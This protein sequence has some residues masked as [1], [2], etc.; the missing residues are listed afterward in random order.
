M[1]GASQ[2]YI[3]LA[4]DGLVSRSLSAGTNVITMHGMSRSPGSGYT[5]DTADFSAFD[6]I[7]LPVDGF[8]RVAFNV[9]W[10]AA[11]PFSSGVPGIQ[12]VCIVGGTPDIL[13]NTV[14]WQEWDDT[15]FVIYGEQKVSS[16]YD[17]SQLVS[18]FWFNYSG[19][20]IDPS[21]G[22]GLGFYA[23]GSSFKSMGGGIM[24]QRIGDVLEDMN[25]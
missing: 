7:M 25:P 6:Y 23:P 13:A 2:E 8:Y 10:N 12:P 19:S 9:F 21:F 16:E 15:Q 24:V 1:L 4:Y 17:H 22:V 5:V 11:T 18:N 14:N 20:I 3:A